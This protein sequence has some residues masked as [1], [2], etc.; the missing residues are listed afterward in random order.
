MNE[1]LPPDLSG[2]PNS[3]LV[4]MMAECSDSSDESDKMFLAACRD[5]L[6]RRKP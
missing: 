2:I 6:A 3:G 5:E 1:L 4:D